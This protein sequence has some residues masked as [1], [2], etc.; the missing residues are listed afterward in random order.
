LDLIRRTPYCLAVLVAAALALPASAQATFPGVNGKIAFE[1]STETAE[2]DIF[3]INPD[4]SGEINLTHNGANNRQIA[5]SPD[6]SRIAF[7]SDGDGSDNYYDI[8]VAAADGSGPVRITETGNAHTPAWSPDGQSIAFSDSY[9][10]TVRPDGTGLRALTGADLL[11]AEIPLWSPDGSKI[12]FQVSTQFGSDLYVVNRDGSGLRR[13]TDDADQ[14]PQWPSFSPDGTR[15]AYLTS[16]EPGCPTVE[17]IALHV[18]N[19][20]GTNER[21]LTRDYVVYPTWSPDGS[22]ISYTSSRA[23]QFDLYT[24]KPDGTGEQRLTN[25]VK[26][27]YAPK[28]SP[29]STQLV[30]QQDDSVF[31][32]NRDGSGERFVTVGGGPDWQRLPAVD[33]KRVCKDERRSLGNNAFRTRYGRGK[34]GSSAFRNC[35]ASRTAA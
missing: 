19:A 20:D 33:P 8:H 29:D 3:A 28:W 17:C 9:I 25:S 23:G 4:G 5:W 30:F 1:R 26:G 2:H 7:F 35:V 31:V 6:G 15:I 11:Y 24:I 34:N 13:V 12:V 18:M 21:K 27:V 16:R 14:S 10:Y 32:I 22:R